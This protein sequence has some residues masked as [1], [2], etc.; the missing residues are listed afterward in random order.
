MSKVESSNSK[1]S[2]SKNKRYTITTGK[3]KS[4]RFT[5]KK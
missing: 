1:K 2:N 4:K 5:Q 3:G